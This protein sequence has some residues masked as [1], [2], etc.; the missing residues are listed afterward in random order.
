MTQ[1]ITTSLDL[2]DHLRRLHRLGLYAIPGWG[3][4]KLLPGTDPRA[5]SLDPPSLSEILTADYSGGLIILAGTENPFGGY[6]VAIDV[7]H[8]PEVWPRMPKRGILLFG[9]AIDPS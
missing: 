8:G 1:T 7:D 6:V 9:P 2:G 3:G 5:L 4:G